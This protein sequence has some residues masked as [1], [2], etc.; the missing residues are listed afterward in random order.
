MEQSDLEIFS[1]PQVRENS[2]QYLL[3]GTDILKKTAAGCPWIIIIINYLIK[4]SR[5]LTDDQARGWLF[6][7][8]H[9]N[10]PIAIGSGSF[11]AKSFSMASRLAVFALL[12]V[13]AV[14]GAWL[15]YVATA[16]VEGEGNRFSYFSFSGFFFANITKPSHLLQRSSL[17]LFQLLYTQK[18][19]VGSQ[20]D[21]KA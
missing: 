18:D 9:N 19:L 6:L 4:T 5:C 21:M 15:N 1:R 14:W 20:F 10:C 13:F 17:E 16:R 12:L 2:R 7:L 11:P 3:L 8:Y